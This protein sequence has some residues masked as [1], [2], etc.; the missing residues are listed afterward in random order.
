VKILDSSSGSAAR[1]YNYNWVGGVS[2]DIPEGFV[3]KTRQFLTEF[4][5]VI[6]EENELLSFN[7][8]L[9]S[10]PPVSES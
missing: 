8:I 5:P 2:H 1:L 10:G 4:E 9:S 6:A 7:K 3:E